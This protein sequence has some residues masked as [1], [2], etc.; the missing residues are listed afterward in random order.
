MPQAQAREGARL[1][2]GP[3]PALQTAELRAPNCRGVSDRRRSRGV[4]LS[5]H[6]GFSVELK[7]NFS[8]TKILLSL[9]FVLTWLE[10]QSNHVCGGRRFF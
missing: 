6:Q 9:A 3:G 4:V 8:C 7:N 10:I 2:G 5:E 1:P